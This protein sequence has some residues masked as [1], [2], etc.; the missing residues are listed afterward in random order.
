MVPDQLKG[1]QA[2]FGLLHCYAHHKSLEQ[3]AETTFQK[4]KE[5][6]FAKGVCYNTMLT[7]YSHMGKYRKIDILVKEIEEKGIGYNLDTLSILL[8]SYAATSDIDR[9]EKLLLKMEADPL[10]TMDW[11]NYNSAANAFLRVGLREK[12]QTLLRRSEQLI[13]LKTRKLLMNTC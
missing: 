11:L 3:A 6:G 8:N 7:L 2:Y 10:V 5:L 1:L 9:M 13:T 12:A 4:M